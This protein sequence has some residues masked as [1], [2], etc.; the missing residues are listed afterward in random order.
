MSIHVTFHCL[1]GKLEASA[2]TGGDIVWFDTKCPEGT[3]SY[4]IKSID[5][6]RA[7]RAGA[8]QLVEIF[9]HGLELRWYAEQE[10]L[11]QAEQDAMREE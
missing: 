2:E 7:L 1:A 4:F 11:T 6:A 3:V 5:D 9:E 10:A 8:Q